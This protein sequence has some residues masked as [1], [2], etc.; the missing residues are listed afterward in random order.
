MNLCGI[1]IQKTVTF[2]TYIPWQCSSVGS[3]TSECDETNLSVF[4]LLTG[5][6]DPTSTESVQAL[7]FSHNTSIH[8]PNH[9]S[10]T[11]QLLSQKHC[12][13]ID[14]MNLPLVLKCAVH[15]YMGH[16]KHSMFSLCSNFCKK[17]CN[18]IVLSSKH[19]K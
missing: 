11:L 16:M 10:Y 7:C 8:K 6:C 12:A 15:C 13:R 1:T 14:G 5:S 4:L 2:M 3:L 19:N 9:P 18:I 17:F